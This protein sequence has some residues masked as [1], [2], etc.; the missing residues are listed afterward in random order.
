MRAILRRGHIGTQI[1]EGW[2]AALSSLT[3]GHDP[4]SV[5]MPWFGQAVDEAGGVMRLNRSL[6]AGLH[7]TLDYDVTGS[8]VG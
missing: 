1:F 7:L 6:F 4:L 8:V 2:R 3:H 5:V